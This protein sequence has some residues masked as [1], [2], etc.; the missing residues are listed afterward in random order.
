MLFTAPRLVKRSSSL[1][2]SRV[3]KDKAGEIVWTFH[4]GYPAPKPSVAINEGLGLIHE[5]TISV[6]E[7]LQRG[8]VWA[9]IG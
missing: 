1:P 8:F 3:R 4:P 2:L 6:K 5:A 9:K 7:A